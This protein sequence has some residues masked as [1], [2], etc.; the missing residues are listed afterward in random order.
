MRNTSLRFSSLLI[1]GF[2]ILLTL[3]L[4]PSF[5]AAQSAPAVEQFWAWVAEPAMRMT[6]ASFSRE[7]KTTAETEAF[8][9]EVVSLQFAVRASET[10]EPFQ[11]SCAEA[12][13]EKGI[14]LP[15]SWAEI[16]Y[17]GYLLVDEFGQYMSD[18]LL[19]NPPP[20][21]EA[22]WTQAVWL[23]IHIPRDAQPGM[24]AGKLEIR[25]G[26]RQANFT[27][28][29]RVLEFTMPDLREGKFYLNIWQDPAAVARWAKVPLWS[30]EHWKLLEAYARDL[31]EHGQKSITT[32][33]LHD[34][35]RSQTGNV[36]PSM[37]EWRFPGE[38]RPGEEEK[39]QFDYSPFDRYVEIMMKAGV[40]ESIHC[41]SLVNGPG[42]TA[43]CDIGYVDTTTGRLRIRHTTVGDEAYRKA[44]A[45]F[46]RAFV[47]HLRSR[48]WLERT[49]VGFDEKPQ[50]ILDGVLSTLRTNAPELKVALA[51]GSSSQQS[52]RVGDLTIYWDDLAHP[53][54]VAQLLVKRRHA[55]PTVFYTACAPYS[56]NVFLYSPLWESRMLPWISWRFGL[57]GYLRWAYESWPDDLWQQPRF[58]WHSGDN[59]FVYP[60]ENGPISSTRWEMLRQGV[61][62]YEALQILESRIE[63]LRKQPERLGDAADFEKSMRNAVE[64][65]IERDNC[66]VIPNPGASRQRVNRLLAAAAGK[67]MSEITPYT[68]NVRVSSKRSYEDFAPDGNLNKKVWQEAERVRFDQDW[69][70]KRHFL[71]AETQVASFWTPQYVYFAFW[72]KYTTL[73]VYE[74]EDPARERWELWNR[75]VVEV[76]LNPEPER[77]KHYYEFEVAPNN[78]WI[79]LEIDL[80]KTPFNDAG[81]DSHFE[82]ATHIDAEN[83]VWTCEMRI[84]LRS[85]G[86]NLGDVTERSEWRVNFYRADGPGDDSERRFLCWSAVV[87]KPNFHAPTRFG[88]IRFVK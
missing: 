66:E 55:G 6:P 59:Y 5:A 37:V 22:N 50:Q 12:Q 47:R 14:R 88:I 42:S 8:R 52:A 35:W 2:I 61:Q 15:C 72:C 85:M 36:F 62:D 58:H 17:P 13:S 82:H 54:A 26:S 73:N 16:R 4:R 46:L 51:G 78:Q 41:F 30:E 1:V 19:E 20:R 3:S 45:A 48:G 87:D 53:Q 43:D 65:A 63:E 18:P 34:P 27:L 49:Y 39:F 56:P 32:S 38:W 40:K 44:W 74:G 83:H 84:P 24:Y 77:V 64:S 80:D 25:A 86:M 33:I 70:G 69:S 67:P 81:W 76:F 60:G 79:D 57:N 11:V 21:L 7:R 31:A 10:L 75:D 9:N 71:E 29:V 28:N 68:S 23:T